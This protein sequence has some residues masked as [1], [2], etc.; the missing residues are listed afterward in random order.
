MI[1]GVMCQSGD[2]TKGGGRTRE[3]SLYV[4]HLLMTIFIGKNSLFVLSMDNAGLNTTASQLFIGTTKTEWF[5]VVHAVCGK[6]ISEDVLK[7]IKG[8]GTRSGQ[9]T[10]Q[11]TVNSYG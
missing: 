8:C 3:K 11:I 7:S 2:S 1:L 4:I 9:S 6:V 5:A 10:I